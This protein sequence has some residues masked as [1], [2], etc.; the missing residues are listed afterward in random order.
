MHAY[1]NLGNTHEDVRR[2]LL[3]A[4][5]H[6][7]QATELVANLTQISVLQEARFKASYSK[8]KSEQAAAELEAGIEQL[9][10]HWAGRVAETE[11]ANLLMIGMRKAE[12]DDAEAWRT[13]LLHAT[14]LGIERG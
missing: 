8:A 14:I 13:L 1:D 12:L 9:F 6:P 4:V 5:S 7:E 11:L 3:M 10:K 2:I